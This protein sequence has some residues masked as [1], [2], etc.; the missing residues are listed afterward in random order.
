M[1][2]THARNQNAAGADAAHQID[3]DTACPV[4]IGEIFKG[5]RSAYT[6]IVDE[7]IGCATEGGEHVRGCMLH[8]LGGCKIRLHHT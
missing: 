7:D 4:F 5:R 2:T 3:L 8:T 1:L 6:E